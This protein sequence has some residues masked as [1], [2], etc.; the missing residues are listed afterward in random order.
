MEGGFAVR[1]EATRPGR[2]GTHVQ[3]LAAL[4]LDINASVK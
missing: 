3:Q 2:R 4:V 1:R